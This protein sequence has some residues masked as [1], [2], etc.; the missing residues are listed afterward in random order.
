MADG[1][2]MKLGRVASSTTYGKQAIAALLNFDWSNLGD[3]YNVCDDGIWVVPPSSY[4]A[5]LMTPTARAFRVAHPTGDLD[6]P[7]LPFPFTAGQFSAFCDSC[8]HFAIDHIDAI[9]SN[10]DDS[11]DERALAELASVSAPAAELVRALLAGKAHG[12]EQ[13]VPA[14]LP[15]PREKAPDRHLRL[16]REILRKLG[17]EGESVPLEKGGA[18]GSD[19]KRKAFAMATSAEYAKQGLTP[20]TFKSAWE[21]LPIKR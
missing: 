9:Y 8:R 3:Y 12:T 11:L 15:P 1:Q 20:R 21:R 7:A 16:L 19:L 13:P 14:A 10:D 6:R 17:H 2:A 18:K 5:R 4:E